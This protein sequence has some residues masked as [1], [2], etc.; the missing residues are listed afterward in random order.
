MCCRCGPEKKDKKDPQ[1][2]IKTEKEQKETAGR[3]WSWAERTTEQRPRNRRKGLR[4]DP[5]ESKR[6]GLGRSGVA[7][8]LRWVVGRR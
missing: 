3:N 2:I 7:G 4:K 5:Q 8:E 6:Q 1:K